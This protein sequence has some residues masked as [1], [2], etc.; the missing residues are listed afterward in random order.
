[1]GELESLEIKIKASANDVD[2]KVQSLIGSLDNLEN[3]L[4]RVGRVN[5]TGLEKTMQGLSNAMVS[6]KNSGV[7]G[8]E[9]TSLA[10]GLNKLAN[11]DGGKLA[12]TG[13]GI[14]ALASG[15]QSLNGFSVDIGQLSSLNTVLAR[16]SSATTQ[17]S[18]TT[19]NSLGS[20]LRGFIT[21]INGLPAVTFDAGSM[22]STIN[23]LSQI[24][25]ARVTNASATLQTLVTPLKT[26][27]TE[28]NQLQGLTF[29]STGLTSLAN[30]ISVLGRGTS[31]TAITNMDALAK[32]VI[33]LITALS[34]A[35]TVN[36]NTIRLIT[37]LSQ[38]T[39]QGSK[40]G[41]MANRLT[42]NYGRLGSAT[43]K[44]HKHTHSLASTI[45]KIY[46][47]FF[48][49]FRAFNLLKEA[50]NY[51]S[52]LTEVQNVIDNTFGVSTSDAINANA[53]ALER[54]A[55]NS[56]QWYG[57]S[58]LT[59]KTIAGQFEAMGNA[60]GLSSTKADGLSKNLQNLLGASASVDDMAS[61]MS[62]DLTAL[63]GDMA[64]FY[65]VE[66]EEVAASLQSG[67][68]SGQARA[69]RAYGMDL[70]Q[71]TLQ[72]YAY[73]QGIAESVANMTQAEK[74]LLRYRYVMQATENVQ[75]DFVNTQNT[76]ANQ[77]RIL[78]QNLQTFGSI[79]GEVVIHA[80]KNLVIALNQ[81][82]GKVISFTRQIANALGHIFGWTI[83]TSGG[84][85]D[86]GDL[87]EETD[88][89]SGSL[90]DATGSAKKLKN[91]LQGFDNLNVITTS[92]DS[93]G[94][95]GGS[96]DTSGNESLSWDIK[97]TSGSLLSYYE[98][99][100]N[101]LYQLGDTIQAKLVEAMESIDWD[102]IYGKA[103]NFGKGL[104][105]FLNGL[106]T[107][108]LFGAM[109]KT[110]GG[111]INTAIEASF[112]FVTTFNWS[113]FGKSLS[114]GLTEGIDTINWTKLAK[115]IGTLIN[116]MIT[117]AMSFLTAT[118]WK[119]LGK[120]LHNF[121]KN[122]LNS[123]D[124][125]GLA[126][127]AK[128]CITSILDFGGELT[129]LGKGFN[130]LASAVGGVWLAFKGYSILKS[131][132]SALASFTSTVTN[133][134]GI[135]SILGNM[136]NNFKTL[137][138]TISANSSTIMGVGEIFIAVAGGIA[139]AQNAYDNAIISL[140]GDEWKTFTNDIEESVL[141]L[142]DF[143]TSLSNLTDS[144][145]D[146]I[147]NAEAEHKTIEGLITQYDSLSS[148]LEP[149]VAQK[150]QLKSIT[151]D[152]IEYFPQ[153]ASNYDEETGLIDATTQSLRNLNDEK[154][155]SA[156][157]EASKDLYTE[158]YSEYLKLYDEYDKYYDNMIKAKKKYE[159]MGTAEY[160]A[161][162][163]NDVGFLDSVKEAKEAYDEAT[164]AYND[165][166]DTLNEAADKTEEL[167]QEIYGTSSKLKT[168]NK[169][170]QQVVVSSK[171]L[172]STMSNA[173]EK[174]MDFA[175]I[176]GKTK[177][178]ISA[179]KDPL[180]AA[181]EKTK[182]WNTSIGLL[183]GALSLTSGSLSTTKAKVSTYKTSVDNATA[184]TARLYTY[185]GKTFSV[186]TN[187]TP[188]N[189]LKSVAIGTFSN[190]NSVFT[191]NGR[192]LN[193]NGD[194]SSM[195]PFSSLLNTVKGHLSSVFGYNGK[196]VN[197]YG[198]NGLSGTNSTA[199]T[200]K[201]NL[202]SVF[203]YNGRT[204]EVNAAESKLS[205]FK[206]TLTTIKDNL[207]TIFGYNGKTVSVSGDVN[208]ISGTK[209]ADGGVFTNGVWKNI[210]KYASGGIPDMGQ[211]FIARESG[212]ELVGSLSG[213]T[214]VMN[215]DQIVSSVANGVYMAV[216]SAMGSNNGNVNVTVSLEGDAQ[217]LFKAVRTQDNKYRK[218]NGHSAF[219][220]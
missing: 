57:M 20:A 4:S 83:E 200:L 87:T 138:S 115:T 98:S 216:K 218:V 149:T 65:N 13:S 93:D 140:G 54:F 123:I 135:G 134:K 164:D 130:V 19:L 121:I 90:D 18:A 177:S 15:I 174:T 22:Q 1:M 16:F 189:L 108:D 51:S 195:T 114:K 77:T 141:K 64:S 160:I 109:G 120:Q 40:V 92:S 94:S 25:G 217:G 39:A 99:E 215:N 111:A 199:S 34:Q 179:L 80:L 169:A 35:P 9:F 89:L 30:A 63:A 73:S 103:K 85:A 59:T 29:D 102:S 49:L 100:I 67:V 66:A 37:S 105:D 136:G 17:N 197:V 106:I 181:V 133:A 208:K 55:E 182:G 190:L 61:Q 69:L 58:A 14:R 128:E 139:I 27:I 167:G 178:E 155:K 127:L 32:G 47:K 117:S 220:Y 122:A 194:R 10:N 31:Q 212:P 201:S 72:E 193:V 42:T 159:K 71:A 148:V 137:G 53:D 205:T 62:L 36:E 173:S 131:A 186:P 163:S 185:N 79:I 21:Q 184:S 145:N 119:K 161:K 45:G 24:G 143:K 78:K 198:N 175:L 43:K 3:A 74:T 165:Y 172:S 70:T 214:A 76:W 204:L 213:H 188:L 28:I 209:K 191:Y 82:L 95:G 210:G 81:T 171:S 170:T 60:M 11:V 118:D 168:V 176:T 157:L 144:Y 104:A 207:L 88:S 107:P 219:A 206:S 129:G 202:S 126:K 33:N 203:S 86:L 12:S 26:F 52:D 150:E 7:T 50:V 153:L 68:M 187:T 166:C 211:M 110:I 147:A 125:K 142:D 124:W 101:N 48:L 112:E 2:K 41:T 192:T 116:G 97:K 162:H 183:D 8:R 96:S 180:A 91:A 154:L 6:Y 46:A 132:D 158:Y 156:K 38:L 56:V 75:G 113:K 84:N 44:L 5:I 23:A 196:T 152:L 151:S 146:S